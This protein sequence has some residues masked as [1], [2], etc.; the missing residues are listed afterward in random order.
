M[1]NRRA[2]AVGSRQSPV[3]GPGLAAS[4]SSGP[5]TQRVTA[6]G[7]RTTLVTL[8]VAQTDRARA[9]PD[10]PDR[11]EPAARCQTK[12]AARRPRAVRV[13]HHPAM[14]TSAA[15]TARPLSAWRTSSPMSYESSS[16]ATSRR[17]ACASSGQCRRPP[18]A[19]RQLSARQGV[20][21]GAFGGIVTRLQLR[22]RGTARLFGTALVL[23]NAGLYLRHLRL[24]GRDFGSREPHGCSDR[25][26]RGSRGRPPGEH[27]SDPGNVRGRVPAVR[28]RR[29]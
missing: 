17:S 3:Q 25:R 28:H 24:C 20:S 15:R 29:F 5:R 2:A 6:A 16:A 21:R 18:L 4:R 1:P 26:S 19:A 12:A 14:Q 11:G 10:D 27:V 13:A 23:V 8:G 9:R 7:T 22:G